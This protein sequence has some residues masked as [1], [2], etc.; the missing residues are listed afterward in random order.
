MNYGHDL[1]EFENEKNLKVYYQLNDQTS[2][3]FC[4]HVIT[5]ININRFQPTIK[6]GLI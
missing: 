1:H 4:F 5:R 6:C 3:K 2:E